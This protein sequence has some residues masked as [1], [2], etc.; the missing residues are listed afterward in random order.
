[1]FAPTRRSE[2][3]GLGRRSTRPLVV[4]ALCA[5]AV[6]ISPPSARAGTL[7]EP[8]AVGDMVT[9]D[10]SDAVVPIPERSLNDVSS[11]RLTHRANRVAIR[12]DY[13]DLKRGGDVQGLFIPVVTNEGVRRYLEVVAYQRR[14]SGVT[15]MYSGKWRD[16]GCDRVRHSIDYEANTLKVS[17]P[18]TCV[19]NPRW[20]K[21]RVAAYAQGDGFHVDDALDDDPLASQD[22]DDLT[23]SRKV[24][25]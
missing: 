8:D 23:W 5:A 20:V 12:V 14:W 25:R 7:T 13:V 4:A 16:V 15:E 18:R 19:S 21:F 24:R 2:S 9:F 22:D 10:E 17:F 6:A 1:M 11:T 3:P